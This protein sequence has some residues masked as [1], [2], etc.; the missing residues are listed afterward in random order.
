MVRSRDRWTRGTYGD[1]MS[2]RGYIAS[3][4]GCCLL[5]VVVLLTI[6]SNDGLD[7]SIAQAQ[8]AFGETP[9]GNNDWIGNV[10]ALVLFAAGGVLLLIGAV[11]AG[12]RSGARK[13]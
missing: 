7:Q 12:V 13:D 1:E 9:D 10:V 3:G 11:G 4:V 5:A 2:P 8:M 6:H